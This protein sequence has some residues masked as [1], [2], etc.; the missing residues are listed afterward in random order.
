VCSGEDHCFSRIPKILCWLLWLRSHGIL[1]AKTVPSP[2]AEVEVRV[3]RARAAF[4]GSLG[5]QHW[6]A[7]CCQQACGGSITKASFACPAAWKI[8]LKKNAKSNQKWCACTAIYSIVVSLVLS[9]VGSP[10]D[11]WWEARGD[12][13]SH[14]PFHSF[15]ARVTGGK[16]QESTGLLEHR[17]Q[18]CKCGW[19]EGSQQELPRDLCWDLG[20]LTHVTWRVRP[21][22]DLEE[23]FKIFWPAQSCRKQLLSKEELSI[24]DAPA[25]ERDG[26]G[27]KP[28]VIREGG[29]G[30]LFMSLPAQEQWDPKQC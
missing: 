29:K 7:T 9:P 14:F 15:S 18:E 4:Q 19:A 3:V 6:P 26:W 16:G 10:G 21:G 1:S 28:P 13:D 11:T 17:E 30:W 20:S 8:Q 22:R 5:S 27:L 2:A 24:W 23:L 25:W 12:T